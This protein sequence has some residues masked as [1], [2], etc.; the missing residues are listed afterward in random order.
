[1]KI[2][3]KVLGL[4]PSPGRL[5]K[6]LLTHRDKILNTDWGPAITRQQSDI[7]THENYL[8]DPG[9]APQPRQTFQKLVDTLRQKIKWL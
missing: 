2:T 6:K 9:F 4:L 8:K 1:M 5:F 3:L 7:K